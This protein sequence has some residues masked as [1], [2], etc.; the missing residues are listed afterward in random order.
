[1]K[2]I[3]R[4]GGS[5]CCDAGERRPQGFVLSDLNLV[6]VR[7]P[8]RSPYVFYWARLPAERIALNSDKNL[9]LPLDT[10][11]IGNKLRGSR[12]RGLGQ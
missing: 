10:N 7:R 3:V 8:D 4:R 1:M 12:R 9:F 11:K 2:F 6:A 5:F